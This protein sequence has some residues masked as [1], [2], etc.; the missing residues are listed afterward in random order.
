MDDNVLPDTYL[1]QKGKQAKSIKKSKQ[2]LTTA[3]FVT[4]TGETNCYLD[5]K[6]IVI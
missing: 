3:F 1:V 4:P 2:R 6:P 5:D